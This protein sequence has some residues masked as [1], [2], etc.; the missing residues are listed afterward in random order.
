MK[1]YKYSCDEGCRVCNKKEECKIEDLDFYDKERNLIV[2]ISIKNKIIRSLIVYN[3][4][5][6]IILEK[7][8]EE[9]HFYLDNINGI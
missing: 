6:D 7:Y 1:S 2:C 4:D 9:E 3:D 5:Q 8:Y